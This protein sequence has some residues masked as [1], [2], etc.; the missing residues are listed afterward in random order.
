MLILGADIGYGDI[1]IVFM[2]ENKEILKKFKFPSIVGLTKSLEH[3][4]NDKIKEYDGNFYM[5]GENAKH[6]PSSNMI[7]I[8][9]YKN[10]EYFGPLLLQEA[11]DTAKLGQ[12]DLIVAGLSIAQIDNS[13]YFEDA[14]SKYTINGKEY[15]N[16]VKILPQG[17][18]AKITVSTYGSN[19]PTVLKDYLGDKTFVIVDMGFNTLDLVLVNN[20]KTDPNLFNGIEKQGVMKIAS[21]VAKLIYEKHNR[22]IT[23]HEAKEVIDSNVYR[24][25]GQ[26]YNYEN[27]I[28]QI[29][30]DYLKEILKLVETSYPSILDKADF[31]FLCGGGSSIF[32]QGSNDGFLR[33]P[34]S[35]HEY[36]NAIGQALFGLKF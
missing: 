5:I 29:K 3:V 17:A 32:K 33:T 35:N 2:N 8:I 6:L 9:D 26:R 31:I 14:I 13:A 28:K 30:E 12:P 4:E 10:L 11:I 16:K 21:K 23:L 20:G 18:G 1:K 25:R 24:L 34:E 19:F 15:T 22:S 7:D 36:Y 27:E